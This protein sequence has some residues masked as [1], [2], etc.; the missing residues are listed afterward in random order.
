MPATPPTAMP[1]MVPGDNLFPRAAD[2][3]GVLCDEP[4]SLV[5]NGSPGDLKYVEFFAAAFCLANELE[6]FY[7]HQLCPSLCRRYAYWVDHSNHSIILARFRGRAVEE[8]RVGVIDQE[9]INWRLLI[10]SILSD[11]VAI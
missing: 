4:S 5:G 11:P 10:I 3:V 9:I 8:D 7:T 6:A 2:G 1:A